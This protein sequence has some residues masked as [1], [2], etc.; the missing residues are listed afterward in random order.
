[1]H[2]CGFVIFRPMMQELLNIEQ[3]CERNLK[4][5]KLKIVGKSG[6]VDFLEAI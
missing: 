1:M 3:F 5:L 4:K 2:Q 6:Q